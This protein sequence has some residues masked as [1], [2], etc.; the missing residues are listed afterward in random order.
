MAFLIV[1]FWL[2]CGVAILLVGTLLRYASNLPQVI[3]DLLL[4]GKVRGQRKDVTA[5]RKIEIP[6]RFFIH[7]YAIG[8][9]AQGVVLLIVGRSYFMGVAP[10][11]LYKGVLD[12]LSE[13]KIIR[14]N[15]V[16]ATMVIALMFIQ[17]ARRLYECIYI[18]VYSKGTINLLHYT[19]GIL[20]YSTFGFAALAEA[21][22][23]ELYQGDFLGDIITWNHAVGLVLFIWATWHHHT[24]HI[25][26]ANLRKT[27]TGAVQTLQHQ[28]PSGD[29][30]DYVSCPHYL[31][32]C[33]IYFSFIT[34]VG[35]SNITMW[36]IVLFVWMNQYMAAMLCH[37]W[38]KK[39]FKK[40][41]KER[42]AIIPFVA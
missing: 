13:P 9:L 5:V 29:W 42:R 33:I 26:F 32:E 21:P 39:E 16:S 23:L 22:K 4:Y 10:P 27:K 1:C 30:F 35:Y 38:Y 12:Y 3:Q 34:I 14:T 6:K 25:I 17:D 41:P 40:Y 15:A 31:A 11:A 24:A 8:V 19:L 36:S 28:I 20:L 2:V 18:S 7:F 37:D